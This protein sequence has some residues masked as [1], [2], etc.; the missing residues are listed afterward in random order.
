[1]ING[2]IRRRVAQEELV[3]VPNF[4]KPVIRRRIG[5]DIYYRWEWSG[6][7]DWKIKTVWRKGYKDFELK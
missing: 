2:L 1:M 3:N 4:W 6:L 5:Y 7:F